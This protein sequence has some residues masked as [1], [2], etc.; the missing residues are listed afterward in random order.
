MSKDPEDLKGL[1][2]ELLKDGKTISFCLAGED[3]DGEV[4][5]EF[6]YPLYSGMKRGIGVVSSL[7][8][9]EERLRR[10]DVWWKRAEF[11]WKEDEL[12]ALQSELREEGDD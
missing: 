5:F 3:H 8:Q 1:L 6:S 12:K 9:L 11:H 10:M 7:G 2:A 4:I